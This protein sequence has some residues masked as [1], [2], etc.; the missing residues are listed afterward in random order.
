MEKLSLAKLSN[1]S[2]GVKL[3]KN[4]N[5]SYLVKF[6]FKDH[7]NL[8]R[9]GIILC[10]EDNFVAKDMDI[11]VKILI[12]HCSRDNDWEDAYMVL[13]KLIKMITPEK[14]PNYAFNI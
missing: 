9:L 5:G 1:V 13:G 12:N 14:T 8:R 11:L 6:C 3:E 2:G 4:D 7:E 10:R